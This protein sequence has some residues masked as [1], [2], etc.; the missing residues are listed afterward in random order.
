M[1]NFWL[2]K[3]RYKSILITIITTLLISACNSE[4][5]ANGE[6]N[7]NAGTIDNT[8]INTTI[9]NETDTNEII[10][11]TADIKLSWVA[12]AEREDNSAISLSDIAGYKIYYGISQASYDISVS[13]DDGSAQ[14]H[15]FTNL[16]SGTYYFVITTRDVDGRKS[17][18]SSEIIITI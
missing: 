2:R 10:A 7:N 11:T 13:I 3:A 16:N 4:N 12:P 18:Y 5:S 8:V 17:Q 15:T 14:G 1:K 6:T 9:S